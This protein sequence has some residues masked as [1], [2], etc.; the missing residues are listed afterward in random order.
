M[1]ATV[2]L[3]IFPLQSARKSWK[4][5]DFD[6]VKVRLLTK[7]ARESAVDHRC[8]WKKAVSGVPVNQS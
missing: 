8:A 5:A 6:E 2:V 1:V 3:V 7:S 4:L